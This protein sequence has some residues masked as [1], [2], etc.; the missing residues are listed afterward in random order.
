MRNQKIIQYYRK[1]NYGVTCE[2]VHPSCAGDAKIIQQL[3]GHRTITGAIRE[4]IRDLTGGSV[5]FVEVIA[6]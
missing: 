5:T 2:Y 6:P 4:L 3:T 1:S